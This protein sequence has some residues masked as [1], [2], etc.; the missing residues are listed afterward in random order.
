[1][2]K[3]FRLSRRNNALLNGSP[4]DTEETVAKAA[5]LQP[6]SEFFAS[7]YAKYSF[8]EAKMTGRSGLEN[9]FKK[10]PPLL[11]PV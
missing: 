5:R 11:P 9:V 8:V 3:T 4:R 1:M 2:P 10:L 7:L 6:H